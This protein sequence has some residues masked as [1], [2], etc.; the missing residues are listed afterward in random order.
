MEPSWLDQVENNQINFYKP[1]LE[2]LSTYDMWHF[3][4]SKQ[5]IKSP[6]ASEKTAGVLEWDSDSRASVSYLN[7]VRA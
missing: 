3:H 1:G 4:Q 5:N 2:A 7:A 6:Q